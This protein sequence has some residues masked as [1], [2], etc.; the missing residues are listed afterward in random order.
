MEQVGYVAREVDPSIVWSDIKW[1]RDR[2][3][4][5]V[6]IKGITNVDDAM[7]AIDAG[8]DGIVVSNHG[9]RQLD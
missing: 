5:R 8:A 1:L 3:K 2:W 4:G 7:Q 6:V 9:G